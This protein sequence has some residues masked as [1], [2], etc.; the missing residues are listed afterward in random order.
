[1]TS[2]YPEDQ[3]FPELRVAESRELVER[4]V[5]PVVEQDDL[6]KPYLA[7]SDEQVPAV[8]VAVDEAVNEDQLAEGFGDGTGD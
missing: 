8:R 2:T 1:M 4:L 6:Q 7:A 5:E 3:S